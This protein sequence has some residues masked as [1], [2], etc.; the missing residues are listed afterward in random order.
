MTSL[1]GSTTTHRGEFQGITVPRGPGSKRNKMAD[2][3]GQVADLEPKSSICIDSILSQDESRD[4]VSMMVMADE[5]DFTRA[6]PSFYTSTQMG[7]RDQRRR[8]TSPHYRRCRTCP[9]LKRTIDFA[10]PALILE[11]TVNPHHP[12]QVLRNLTS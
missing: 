1:L 2:D 4:I 7:H 8:S 10:V 3:R 12:R 5:L 6:L 11:I 9:G